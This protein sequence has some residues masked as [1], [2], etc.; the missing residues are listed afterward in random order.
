MNRALTYDLALA[1]GFALVAASFGVFAAND[2]HAWGDDWAGYLL[3][4]KSLAAGTPAAELALNRSAMHAS[5]VQ[6]GPGAYPW[7]FPLLLRLAAYVGGWDLS[8][9]KAV[10]ISAVALLAAATFLFARLVM[11][12]APAALTTVLVALQPHVIVNSTLLDSDLTFSALS[13]LTLLLLVRQ[14]MTWNAGDKVP[15][16]HSGVLAIVA[17]GAFAVRS[18]GA[19]IWPVFCVLCVIA[20]HRG[21]LKKQELLAHVLVCFVLSGVIVGAY[22]L[23]LP[24]G[25]LDHAS[26]LSADPRVWA[27]RAVTHIKRISEA[28]PFSA[29]DSVDKRLR[30]LPVLLG[31]WLLAGGVRASPVFAI[32][33]GLFAAA[34]LA[35]LTAFPFD[36]GDRYYYMLYPPMFALMGLGLQRYWPLLAAGVPGAFTACLV[37]IVLA[38]L[39]RGALA[40]EF[41]ADAEDGPYAVGTTAMLRYL[42]SAVPPRAQ[43]A[44]FKPRAMR[45]LS[46]RRAIAISQPEH[47]GDV[48]CV[49]LHLGP[50]EARLQVP[51]NSLSSAEGAPFQRKYDS[52]NFRVYCR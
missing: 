12:R 46:G 26:Y 14:W 34:H 33:C 48:A 1:L 29:M 7:G 18:N 11:D 8:S 20:W 19:V 24:D 2:L 43:I 37:G 28:L 30:I 38:M 17:A 50:D 16:W 52:P 40:E 45:L 15:V 35:L 44:F 49:V 5:D 36:G 27:S 9:L 41:R 4:A 21:I 51:E 23:L 47:L 6:M 13:A 31:L 3:Q 10:G 22:F 32:P 39:A 25:S 42:D